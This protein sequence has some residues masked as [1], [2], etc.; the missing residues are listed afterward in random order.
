[1][2]MVLIVVDETKKEELEV[3]LEEAG[4]VGYTELAPAA[5]LGTTGWK[6]G[7]RA[8]PRSSAVIFSVLEPSALSELTAKVRTFCEHCGERLRMVAWE[9]EEVL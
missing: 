4:V 8:F 6:L 5:G 3:V 7:S 2:K 1:M 9:I